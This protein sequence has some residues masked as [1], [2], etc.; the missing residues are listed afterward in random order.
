MHLLST[1]LSFN[2]K[3]PFSQSHLSLDL[4][5]PHHHHRAV[6]IYY[7]ND[8]TKPMSVR[9][10]LDSRPASSLKSHPATPRDSFMCL[11]KGGYDSLGTRL[12]CM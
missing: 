5:P 9:S 6:L 12:L 8:K 7:K 11:E 2:S 3:G 4:L 1:Y 10:S